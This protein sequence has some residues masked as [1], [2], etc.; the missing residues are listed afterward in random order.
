MK[1]KDLK[2]GDCFDWKGVF[3]IKCISDEW[4]DP[5]GVKAICLQGGKDFY[6]K[7]EGYAFEFTPNEEVTRIVFTGIHAMED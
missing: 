6:P 3:L 5:R 1:F 4:T 2:L 7:A